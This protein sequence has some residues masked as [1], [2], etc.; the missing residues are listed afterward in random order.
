MLI[1]SGCRENS[2]DLT[3]G[4]LVQNKGVNI[5]DHSFEAID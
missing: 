3:E 5:E 4:G 2:N 1:T